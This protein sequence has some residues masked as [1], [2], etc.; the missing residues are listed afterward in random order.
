VSKTWFF[1]N[2]D[3]EFMTQIALGAAAYRAAEAGEV[4]A[5]AAQVKDGDYASWVRVWE[6]TAERVR[7]MAQSSEAAGHRVSAR[8]AYLRASTYFFNA[9][10]FVL[11]TGGGERL[12]QLWRTH[13]DCV[14]RAGDYRLDPDVVRRIQCPV[15]ITDPDDERFW[16]E[17]PRRLAEL[18]GDRATLI[19]FT[20][21]EG[22]DGHCEPRVPTLRAQRI[23]DW[24]DERLGVGAR[25]P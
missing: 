11:G 23:F 6:A 16:P 13:R 10:F 4:L 18:L 14:E 3:F 17:Q 1:K 15:L 25:R 12:P 9:A 21:E 2:D 8:E 20:A 22:A 19:R 7:D 24:L 5:T